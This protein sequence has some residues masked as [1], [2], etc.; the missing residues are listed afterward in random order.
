MPEEWTK[1]PVALLWEEWKGSNKKQKATFD[2]ESH[3]ERF[4]EFLK[5]IAGEPNVLDVFVT[6]RERHCTCMHHLWLKDNEWKEWLHPF[7]SS[8]Q[9]QN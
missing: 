8:L 9:R 6:G 7:W 5:V 2:F 4:I 1:H 3:K